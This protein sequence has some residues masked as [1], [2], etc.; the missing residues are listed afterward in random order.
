M[1]ITL[2]KRDGSF[3]QLGLRED[4]EFKVNAVAIGSLR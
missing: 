4:G 1:Y 3:C 2:L